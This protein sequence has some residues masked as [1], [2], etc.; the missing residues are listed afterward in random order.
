MDRLI[1]AMCVDYCCWKFKGVHGGQLRF[2]LITHH[3]KIL[4]L[5]CGQHIKVF[6]VINHISLILRLRLSTSWRKRSCKNS[7]SHHRET[8]D[9]D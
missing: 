8:K 1:A 5:C 3:L 6:T 4:N 2:S 7:I 9:N